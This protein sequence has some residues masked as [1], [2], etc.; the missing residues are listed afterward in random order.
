MKAGVEVIYQGVL[1]DGVCWRGYSDFLQRVEHPSALGEFSYEVADTKLARRV[2]P[3]F[4][5]QLCFY[6]ELV[7]LIQGVAPEQMH[8]VLGTRETET[9]R[10]AEFAA[11]YRSVKHGFEAT[12][13][14]DPATGDLVR[15][16]TSATYPEPVEHCALCRWEEHCAAQR[17]ADDH[18]S[19]VARIQR[20]QRTRLVE[21]GIVTLTQLAAA[22]PADRPQ[23]IGT[24]AFDTL[25]AHARLTLSQRA[26]GEPRYKLLAPEEGC[27]FAHLPPPSNGDLFFDMEGDPFFDD[28][29]EYLFGCVPLNINNKIPNHNSQIGGAGAVGTSSLRGMRHLAQLAEAGFAIWPFDEMSWPLVV[30]IYPR[31]FTPKGLLKSR[32]LER[33]AHLTQTFPDQNPVLLERAAG[34]EDS[35]DAAISVLA[36][37]SHIGE[38]E[39][40]RP[41][42]P[43]SL[44]LIEGCIWAPDTQPRTVNNQ[45]HLL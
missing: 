32:H 41:F 18:L 14:D 11:Y 20:S 33:R 36:M 25:R 29:L 26:S 27:G 21:R 2:K 38:L 35:F 42:P 43:G 4:L 5:L 28:G 45:S 34:S 13:A 39:N 16:G 12:I 31:L 1:F 15:S 44:Q 7:E 37:A 24:G 9:F 3:Y 19:L 30:E 22:K 40:L 8:V 6:S 17:G 23:R 10:V